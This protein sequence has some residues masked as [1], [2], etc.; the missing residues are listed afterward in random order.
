MN[1]LLLT[2]I[3][4]TSVGSTFASQ[5]YQPFDSKQYFREEED[6]FNDRMDRMEE[7]MLRQ[8]LLRSNQIY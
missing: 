6:R 8:K 2:I 1:T 5:S 7:S 4:L 3:C